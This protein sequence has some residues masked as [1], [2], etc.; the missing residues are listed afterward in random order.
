MTGHIL[1]AGGAEFG[2]R[3][4]EPDRRALALAGGPDAAL[5]IIPTAAAPDHNEGR[6][7]RNGLRWFES[8]GS[9]NVSVL[10]LV[11]RSSAGDAALAEQLG[12]ARLIYL[13]GGFTHYLG[14]TLAGSR[15]LDAMRAAYAA[16]AVVAGSSAGA[17]VL[18]QHYFN[19]ETGQVEPGL[20]F[21]S[22][23]CFLPHH[24][25]FGKGWAARL[26]A[27]L[28]GVVLVGVDEQTGM[29]D[30]APQGQW[31]VSGRGVVTLY[32]GGKPSIYHPGELV[33]I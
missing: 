13:L 24:N 33:K 14:Q 28:P 5:C 3:M 26:A 8:L 11:D 16:G 18:C 10:P 6:A 4:A 23:A 25:T 29:I 20:N 30:D 21:V 15:C 19:P 9:R 17:M 7:G 22:N 31:S 27:A 32:H 12:Q 2:G 1:L